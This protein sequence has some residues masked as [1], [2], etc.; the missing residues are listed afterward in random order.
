MLPVME[1][2]AFIEVL[3]AQGERLGDALT[4]V[5]LATAVPSCPEW[6]V[7]DLLLHVG[8]IHRWAAT[9]V[10]EARGGPIGVEQPYHVVP[11]LPEDEALL[12]WYRDGHAALV[13]TLEQA[14]A[15]LVCWQFMRGSS[16]LAFWARRQTHETTIH[17]VDAELATGRPTPVAADVADDG[18]DELLTC[19]GSSRLRADPEQTLHVHATD[20][21]G[22]WLLRIGPD[23]MVAARVTGDVAADVSVSGPACDLYYALWNRQPWDSLTTTGTTVADL[24]AR[25]SSHVGIRWS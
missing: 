2:K 3:R 14:P 9:V 16:P 12:G 20:T 4:G 13:R 7:R 22:H 6:T 25:W 19:F 8:G 11:E 24:A 1:P 10:G 17:R 5:D 18:I 15:D 21:G 23:R